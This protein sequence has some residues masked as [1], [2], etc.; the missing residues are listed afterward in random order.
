M[1]ILVKAILYIICND[2]QLAASALQTCAWQDAGAEAET[3][4]YAIKNNLR[5]KIS[6]LSSC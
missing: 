4:I 1:P 2:I 5:K 3:A 6:M